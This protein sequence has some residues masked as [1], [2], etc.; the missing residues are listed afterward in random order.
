MIVCVASDRVLLYGNLGGTAGKYTPVPIGTGVFCFIPRNSIYV[1]TII[2]AYGMTAGQSRH[3]A[4]LNKI[5]AVG[6]GLYHE[7]LK[8]S[9]VKAFGKTNNTVKHYIQSAQRFITPL[10]KFSS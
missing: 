10:C 6:R 5:Q 1:E 9:A 7:E 4:L 8:H 2:M 3:N